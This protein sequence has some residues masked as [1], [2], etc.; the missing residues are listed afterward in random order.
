MNFRLERSIFFVCDAL[1]S[2]CRKL[3]LCVSFWKQCGLEIYPR[4]YQID[5][6]SFYAQNRL[7][8]IWSNHP[9]LALELTDWWLLGGSP[10]SS[11]PEWTVYFHNRSY[12][13][14]MM[15][16]MSHQAIPSP[17]HIKHPPT[18]KTSTKTWWMEGIR[19]QPACQEKAHSIGSTPHALDILISAMERR[20]QKHAETTAAAEP[21]VERWIW[22]S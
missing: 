8:T 12:D 2:G 22:W 9:V 13:P 17:F 19:H 15:Y 4:D 16:G 6:H 11:E 21:C 3:P 7:T 10:R 14:F 5:W 20:G 1:C 18:P